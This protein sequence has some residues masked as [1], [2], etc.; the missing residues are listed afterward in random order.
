M[1]FNG[2]KYKALDE[3]LH[4]NQKRI[5]VKQCIQLCLYYSGST[6]YRIIENYYS[7]NFKL[8]DNSLNDHKITRILSDLTKI[9][10]KSKA[11][12]RGYSK[13]RKALKQ[14]GQ[15]NP[16]KKDRELWQQIA[17]LWDKFKK[18]D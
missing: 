9:R 6:G 5:Y 18:T 1:G 16:S 11:L 13:Y 3:R 14:K 7:V 15:R 12:A 8:N 2:T 17:H 10:E 4:I